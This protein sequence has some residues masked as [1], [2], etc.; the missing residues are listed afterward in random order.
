MATF[1]LLFAGWFDGGKIESAEY[2]QALKLHKIN[3][4]KGLKINLEL[5]IGLCKH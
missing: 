3:W 2:E 1:G 4:Q 5:V